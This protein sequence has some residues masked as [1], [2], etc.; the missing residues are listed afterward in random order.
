MCLQ[1]C[2]GFEAINPSLAGDGK[3]EKIKKLRQ[4]EHRPSKKGCDVGKT[5]FLSLVLR[6]GDWSF[7]VN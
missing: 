5:T 3:A 7:P 2:P 4:T 1:E 6:S